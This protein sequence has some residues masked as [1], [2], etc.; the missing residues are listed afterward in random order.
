MVRSAAGRRVTVAALGGVFLC[1]ALALKADNRLFLLT[2][3]AITTD[4]TANEN[5]KRECIDGV[6]ATPQQNYSANSPPGSEVVI[7]PL[8]V[9]LAAQAARFLSKKVAVEEIHDFAKAG[10][11]R[12]LRLTIIEIEGKMGGVF[13]GRKGLTVTAELVQ[14]GKV[15]RTADFERRTTFGAGVGPDTCLALARAARAIGR[16]IAAWLAP[17]LSGMNIPAR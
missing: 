11:A 8:T 2:P 1:I 5:I 3:A 7:N 9:E 13:S 17:V 16:D 15:L 10:D 6:N 4:A 12:V 14:N